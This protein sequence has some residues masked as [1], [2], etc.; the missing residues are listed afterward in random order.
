MVQLEL[1]RSGATLRLLGDGGR[2]EGSALPDYTPKR[3]TPGAQ[4]KAK[5]RKHARGL[6]AACVD[7]VVLHNYQFGAS[8]GSS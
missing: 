5:Q 8:L 6:V 3:T 2:G 4:P 1:Q 7:V